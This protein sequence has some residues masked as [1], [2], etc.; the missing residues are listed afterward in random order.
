MFFFLDPLIGDFTMAKA[1][2][3]V[4]YQV[5]SATLAGRL[6]VTGGDVYQVLFEAW[7]G[8]GWRDVF[9]GS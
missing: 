8:C 2:E 1:G 4:W 5:R 6:R 3:P 9:L 7:E